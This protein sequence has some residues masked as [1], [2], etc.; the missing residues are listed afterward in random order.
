MM[1]GTST[2]PMSSLT[3]KQQQH[4]KKPEKGLDNE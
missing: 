3:H 2:T 4:E 1:L